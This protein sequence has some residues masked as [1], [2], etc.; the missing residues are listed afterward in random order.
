MDK[1]SMTSKSSYSSRPRY[2]DT[3]L[4][5]QHPRPMHSHH[6]EKQKRKSK[7]VLTYDESSLR[8]YITGFHLRKKQRQIEGQRENERKIR[9]Q[10]L[11]DREER[12][13]ELADIIHHTSRDH[14]ITTENANNDNQQ[15]NENDDDNKNTASDDVNGDM[16]Y[17]D[18]NAVVTV[19][20]KSTGDSDNDNDNEVFNGDDQ[21][22]DGNGSNIRNNISNSTIGHKPNKPYTHKNNRNLH[23]FIRKPKTRTRANPYRPSQKGKETGKGVATTK[24]KHC[25]RVKNKR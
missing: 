25:S 4:H 16:Q 12:R 24:G 6:Q 7:L 3:D 13:Q 2:S 21:R 14:R 22:N 17:E 9:E 15:Q 20:R 18:D 23:K 1:H 11:K 19:I 5:L 8:D 10:R